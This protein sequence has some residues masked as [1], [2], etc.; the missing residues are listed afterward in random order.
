MKTPILVAGLF[1]VISVGSE[2]ATIPAASGSQAD[3]QAAIN[4][5]S[6][7]DIVQ[8]PAGAGEDPTSTATSSR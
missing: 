6:A 3:V 7:G 1:L 2:A 4:A 8:V 5:A